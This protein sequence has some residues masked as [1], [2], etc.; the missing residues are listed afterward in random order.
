MGLLDRLSSVIK[1]EINYVSKNPEEV[2]NN[3]IEE[4]EATIIQLRQSITQNIVAKKRA[5]EKYNY[6]L[7]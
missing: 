1:A 5:E 7:S 3:C 6:H 2:V 4:I